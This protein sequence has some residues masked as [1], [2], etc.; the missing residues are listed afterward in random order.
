[1]RMVITQTGAILH[2][3]YEMGIT[4]CE[5]LLWLMEFYQVGH[6][7]GWNCNLLMA[8]MRS[9]REYYALTEGEREE[10]WRLLHWQVRR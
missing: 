4:D 2:R 10:R 3:W 8:E 7:S 6:G 9:A 5:D 1:M